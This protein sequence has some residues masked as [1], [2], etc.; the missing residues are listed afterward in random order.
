MARVADDLQQKMNEARGPPGAAGAL[1]RFAAGFYAEP[2]IAEALIAL[3]DEAGADIVLVLFGLWLGLA[4]GGRLD[5]AGLAAA[6]DVVRPLRTEVVEPLRTL[7]R[8]LKSIADADIQRLRAGVGAV[9]IDAEKAALDRLAAHVGELKASPCDGASRRAHA[10]SN[11]ALC[12][13]PA[14]QSAA[15]SV[16]LGALAGWGE[17]DDISGPGPA[18]PSA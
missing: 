12:L 13:G 1:W 7:R 11:L 5:A 3:Q 14:L 18:R 9:E 15:A 10:K 2:G 4:C 17:R 16:V 8:R 6:A